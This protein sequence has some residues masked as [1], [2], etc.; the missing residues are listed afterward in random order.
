MGRTRDCGVFRQVAN[1]SVM[2]WFR[3]PLLL[4][5]PGT[6]VALLMSYLFLQ[7]WY[8][9]AV[10]ADP[11]VLRAY[12]FGTEAMVS[13]GGWRYHSAA[14]YATSCLLS[15][16]LLLGVVGLFIVAWKKRSWRLALGCYLGLGLA[17]SAPKGLS[18]VVDKRSHDV[19][20]SSIWPP[21]SGA[22]SVEV[23]VGPKR[24]EIDV[25]T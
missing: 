17:I 5:L 19:P 6:L 16:I 1:S 9:V 15:A 18:C 22:R 10:I 7:Q 12:H 3:N 13:H 4:A 14:T 8:Q 25:H 2:H 23:Q 11:V 21:G 24:I 20:K